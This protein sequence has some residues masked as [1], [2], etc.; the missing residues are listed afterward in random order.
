MQ[1]GQ[2]EI[3]AQMEAKLR[4]LERATGCPDEEAERLLAEWEELEARY[5]R[6]A[7]QKPAETG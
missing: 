3:E 6:I 1:T 7:A 5:G 2:S 4:E